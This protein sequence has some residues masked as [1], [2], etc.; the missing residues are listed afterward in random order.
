[1]FLNLRFVVSMSRVEHVAY[2]KKG[3]IC[4]Y[5]FFSGATGLVN[6]TSHYFDKSNLHSSIIR[7]LIFL[8]GWFIQ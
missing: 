3:T 5:I 4:A 2:H 1:M 7:L 6:K 8:I